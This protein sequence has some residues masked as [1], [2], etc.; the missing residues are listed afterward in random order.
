V[1][2]TAGRFLGLSRDAAAR[3]SFFLL[4]PIVLAA[5][6]FQG[7]RDVV[8]GDLPPGSAGPFVVGM[9]AAAGTGLLAIAG[10]LGYVRRHDYTPFVVYRFVMAA[11]IVILIATGTLEATF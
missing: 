10:L 5:V 2:I 6:V 3:F 4:V 8:L 7:T 1:T 9:L 11:I